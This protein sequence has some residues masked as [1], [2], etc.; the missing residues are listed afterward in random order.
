MRPLTHKWRRVR[1]QNTRPVS[2][3]WPILFTAQIST[4]SQS[5]TQSCGRQPRHSRLARQRSRPQR[6][7]SGARLSPSKGRPAAA[8]AGPRGRCPPPAQG[9]VA[10]RLPPAEGGRR[11]APAAPAPTAAAPVAVPTAALRT[12]SSLRARGPAVRCSG[13]P[14]STRARWSGLG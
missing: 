9:T 3:G 10:R 4:D 11:A 7:S 1:L 13:G 2:D 14:T 12:D 6:P 8:A 5:A